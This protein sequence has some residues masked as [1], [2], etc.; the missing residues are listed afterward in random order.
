MGISRS[1]FPLLCK[2]TIV[3]GMILLCTVNRRKDLC[4]DGGVSSIIT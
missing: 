4:Y 1:A 3:Y 2:F